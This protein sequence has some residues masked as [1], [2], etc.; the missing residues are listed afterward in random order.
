MDP[1]IEINDIE[2]LF[3]NLSNDEEEKANYLLSVVSDSLR[4]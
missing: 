2:N 1:F 3:R 4:Q